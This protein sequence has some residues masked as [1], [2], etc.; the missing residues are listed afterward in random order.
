MARRGKL[1]TFHANL[2]Y[3]V[4]QGSDVDISIDFDQ[5]PKSLLDKQ[6]GKYRCIYIHSTEIIILLHRFGP[7]LV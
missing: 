6:L 5:L 2:H 7:G 4:L 3:V 1:N